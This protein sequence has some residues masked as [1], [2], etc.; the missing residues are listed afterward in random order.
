MGFTLSGRPTTSSD[1]TT[2]RSGLT[3]SSRRRRIMLS[4]VL[5]ELLMMVSVYRGAR[6]LYDWGIEPDLCR[7]SWRQG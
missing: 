6:K 7:D 2:Q 1:N 3:S 5:C 4:G